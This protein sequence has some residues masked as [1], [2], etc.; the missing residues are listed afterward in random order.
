MSN[1]LNS[2]QKEII[3]ILTKSTNFNPITV[4]VIANKLDLSSR[5]VLRELPKIELWLEEN[6]FNFV[7]KPGVG[8][9]IDEDEENRE[10][11]LELLEVEKIQKQYTKEERKRIII[12]ELLITSEPLK[13][14]YFTSLLRVSEGTLSSDLDEIEEFMEKFNIKLIRKPGFGV[15][16]IAKEES[17]RKA[18]ISILYENLKEDELIVIF[19]GTEANTLSIQNRLLNFIDKSLIKYVEDIVKE[20]QDELNVKLADNAYVALVV[21][22]S[23]AVRRIENGEK[24]SIDKE[25]LEELK[26]FKEFS[27][28]KRI[29]KKIEEKFN[30][31]IVEDEIGYITMHLKGAKL[32]LTSTS[33]EFDIS[34]LD[35]KEITYHIINVV[36]QE[37]GRNLS[38]DE[39]LISDLTNHLVPA[40]SRLKM[41]LNIR[42][43]LLEEIKDNYIT[44]FN[45]CLKAC[46][47]LKDILKIEEIP[48]SEV[49]YITSH[50]AAAIEKQI[51][52]EKVSVVIA[53]T[54]GIGT[55][56]LLAST[57]KNNFEVL[58]VRGTISIMN[59]N[60]HQLQE[61]G[62]DLIISTVDLDFNYEYIKVST[63]LSEE[64][65]DLISSTIK[66][67]VD[68]KKYDKVVTKNIETKSEAKNISIEN[69]LE[70]STLGNSIVSLIEDIKLEEVNKILSI[71]DLIY[72]ASTTFVN[73]EEEAKNIEEALLNRERLS[74][75]YISKQNIMLLHCKLPEISR[76][77]FGYIRIDKPFVEN[78]KTIEGA[79]IQLIP[80]DAKEEELKILSEIN[81]HLVDENGILSILKKDTIENI[82]IKIEGILLDLYK[83]EV[84][85]K[86]EVY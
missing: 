28:A 29:V 81:S 53:C 33:N 19:K 1:K 84:K 43:P 66:K 7:R 37:F 64:D 46:N 48:E 74:T 9:I 11:I 16:I 52:D 17:I 56:K 79:I 36:K 86:V 82:K 6:E 65:K 73:N 38:K 30:I 27:I 5:T 67:I 76:V 57:L 35:V 59:I 13:L 26:S 62:I 22:L 50:I 85:Q 69:I 24:I 8:L 78:H 14:F 23:L 34:T 77:K 83:N 72:K 68:K 71:E 55:S 21:H 25:I 51:M 32:V 42:N 80:Y 41:K 4:S 47:I 45:V 31:T 75:T 60:L 20:L 44:E 10:L 61:E 70:I 58:D 3:K 49:A 12:S 40:I 39:K 54:T 15:Y 63:I 2:R 18:I